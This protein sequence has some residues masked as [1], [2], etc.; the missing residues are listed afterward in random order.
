[1]RAQIPQC[2]L[3]FLWINRG[4]V[5]SSVRAQ[6]L[7]L[8]LHTPGFDGCQFRS[9]LLHSQSSS[10]FAAWGNSRGWAKTLWP[11]NCVGDQ[12]EAPGGWLWISSPPFVAT[13]LGL[14]RKMGN[15]ALCIFLSEN[16]P[17]QGKKK[18]AGAKTES[19]DRSIVR[20][21]RTVHTAFQWLYYVTFPLTVSSALFLPQPQCYLFFIC[22]LA[23]SFS[24]SSFTSFA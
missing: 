21:L 12:E 6:C 2:C 19:Y 9:W 3:Y 10:L 4:M 18:S 15:F 8:V 22:L 7:S 14:N 16:L 23:I 13:T 20:F 5:G 24:S 1:M 11:C 17:F